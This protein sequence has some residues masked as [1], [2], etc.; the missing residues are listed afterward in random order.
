MKKLLI[1][2]AAAMLTLSAVAQAQETQY[3]S[4]KLYVPLRSGKGAQFRIVHRGL[5]SGTALTVL[6]ADEESGYTR[7]KT[8]RGLEGWIQSQYLSA[9]PIAE[10]QL[11]E[12]RRQL[13]S[14]TEKHNKLKAALADAVES[15]K[16]ANS[17]TEKLREENQLLTQE[18]DSIKRISANA[19]KLD[20]EY[21]ALNETYQRLKDEVDLLQ[22]ENTRLRDNHENEAFINGALAVLIGVILA[23]VVPRLKPK[24]R[25]DW[26]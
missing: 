16:A 3:I 23:I 5:P 22:T 6:E 9:E 11:I 7:V 14:L 17:S 2:L 8:R 10:L 18:L 26:A 13:Q 15:G 1:C 20:V 4:D 24:K 12:A 25:S 19:I 21:Q